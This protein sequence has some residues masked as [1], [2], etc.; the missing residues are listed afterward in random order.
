MNLSLMGVSMF[1]LKFILSFCFF[2][3]VLNKIYK[4]KNSKIQDTIR[5]FLLQTTASAKIY[6]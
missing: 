1:V 6:R 3:I 4:V 5:K 2:Q